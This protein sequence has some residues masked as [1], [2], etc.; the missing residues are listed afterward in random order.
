MCDPAENKLLARPCRYW[1]LD[2]V[3]LE[4]RQAARVEAARAGESVGG[5]IDHVL[6]D[7]LSQKLV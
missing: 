7:V 6:R 3:S 1:K 2:G 5:W 4:V